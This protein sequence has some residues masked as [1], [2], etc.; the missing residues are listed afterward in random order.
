MRTCERDIQ[1]KHAMLAERPPTLYGILDDPY[2]QPTL[3]ECI[4]CCLGTHPFTPLTTPDNTGERPFVC[5][6]PNCG[7]SF[8]RSGHMLVHVR[9]VHERRSSQGPEHGGRPVK[10]G[11]LSFPS[12]F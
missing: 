8:T 5:T 1:C 2:P 12:P 9:S 7:K 11:S 3:L 6:Y 10:V 4:L